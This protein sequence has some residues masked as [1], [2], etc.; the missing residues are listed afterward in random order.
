MRKPWT[1]QPILFLAAVAMPT[2]AWAEAKSG[3]TQPRSHLLANVSA[4]ANSGDAEADADAASDIAAVKPF[5]D[6]VG[7]ISVPASQILPLTPAVTTVAA[8]GPIG[9]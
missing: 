7:T 9:G 2:V 8:P 1:T 3:Q 5:P 4:P 6:S